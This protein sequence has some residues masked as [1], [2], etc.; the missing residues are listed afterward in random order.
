MNFFDWAFINI[1][2]LV[3]FLIKSKQ[4]AKWSAFLYFNFYMAAL[5]V[6]ICSLSGILYP[7]SLSQYLKTNTI[8]FVLI[9]GI[10]SPV[11]FGIRYFKIVNI[12]QLYE[13]NEQIWDSK[14]HML[15]LLF[16]LFIIGV[17]L[18]SFFLYRTSL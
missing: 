18:M 15:K 8:E 4:D 1:F 11:I 5:A 13:Q 9:V 2:R 12:E 7:N 10:V 14:R 16:T 3:S 6:S 17:P